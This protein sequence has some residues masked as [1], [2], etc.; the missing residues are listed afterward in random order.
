MSKSEQIFLL[1]DEGRNKQGMSKAELAQL[2]GCTQRAIRYWERGERSISLDMA[3]KALK[4]LGLS[5]TI[6]KDDAS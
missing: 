1:I 3:D 2:I 4:A 6:G 5:A